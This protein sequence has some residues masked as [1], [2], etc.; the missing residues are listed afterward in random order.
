MGGDVVVL[1][2]VWK[3]YQ[4]QR[5]LRGVD[6]EVRGGDFIV[7]RGRSGAGKSTLLR[8]MG[9]LTKPDEGE[10]QV[11]GRD[12]R[13]LSDDEASRIRL[14]SIGFIHQFFNLIPTLTVLENVE[15]PLA[16][17][18]V[19]KSERRAKAIEILKE[20]G[21]EGFETRFPHTLSGGER[22]RVAIARAVITE[23]KMILAD[24][25][26]SSLDDENAEAI[27]SIL[28]RLNK[29]LGAAIVISTTELDSTPPSLGRVYFLK[30]GILHSA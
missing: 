2:G 4:G 13:E 24:E 15:L 11:L 16:L 9:L 20:L 1:R 6:L 30:G 19:G 14:T 21:L 5:I 12:V 17:L 28:R 29:E 18:G 8:I 27:M 7:I 23:P 10:V 25:P 22:Q 3:S 26:T